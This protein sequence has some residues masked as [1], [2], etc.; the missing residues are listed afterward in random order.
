MSGGFIYNS[1]EL[2][3]LIADNPDLPIVVLASEEAN[4]GEWEW[5]YCEHVF[6]GIDEV[7]CL[8][9]M[10]GYD[11]AIFNNTTDLQEAIIDHMRGLK[12]YESMADEEFEE[13]VNREFCMYSES[14]QKVIAI[15]ATN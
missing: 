7:L 3:K 5:Q 4:G 2:R 1:A 8:E 13:A 11:R 10:F 15:Y 9:N 6:C 12:T 14:W